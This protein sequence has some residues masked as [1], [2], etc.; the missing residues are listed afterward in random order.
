MNRV[1]SLL[2]ILVEALLRLEYYTNEQ[3][4]ILLFGTSEIEDYKDLP[5]PS[6]RKKTD[7]IKTPRSKQRQRKLGQLQLLLI[8]K[9]KGGLLSTILLLESLFRRRKQRAFNS[10]ISQ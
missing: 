5:L 1:K 8:K 7:Q 10:F 9:L 6:E 2:I 3:L 4:S